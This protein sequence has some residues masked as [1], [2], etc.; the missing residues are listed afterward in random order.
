MYY[1]I[2]VCICY[3]K[4][5]QPTERLASYLLGSPNCKIIMNQLEAWGHGFESGRQNQPPLEWSL[6]FYDH[7]GVVGK[8]KN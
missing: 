7:N 6:P 3:F 1:D 4:T 5:V 8:Q 2:T